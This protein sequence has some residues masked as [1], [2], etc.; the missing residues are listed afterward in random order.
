VHVDHRDDPITLGFEPEKEKEKKY[1]Y[2]YAYEYFHKITIAFSKEGQE[3]RIA[4]ERLELSCE[5]VEGELKDKAKDEKEFTREKKL[6][7]G[8][9]IINRKERDLTYS[10]QPTRF[11]I[12]LDNIY[13]LVYLRLDVLK[14]AR[15][16]KESVISQLFPFRAQFLFNEIALYDIEPKL[17]Q[18]AIPIT[19]KTEL[20]SNGENLALVLQNILEDEKKRQRF[21][22]LIKDL[23]PFIEEIEV[24]KTSDKSL[25]T[26]LEEVYSRDQFLPAFLLSEG[27][28]TITA[29]LIIFYFEEKPLVIIEEPA[30][31]IHPYL[32][33]KVIDMMKD[34]SEWKNKQIIV[35]T[36]NPEIVRYGGVKNLLFVHRDDNGFSRI[37]KPSEKKEVQ[38]FLSNKMGI[39]E[40][41]IQNLLKW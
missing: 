4:G 28:L 6:L 22:K 20:E 26:H 5:F 31:N 25:V 33:A 1:I 36:H 12:S 32:I 3:Y 34:V 7:D 21:K 27:T 18:H 10:I 41:Y 40:L 9:I 2:V 8:K 29:L 30:K 37:S 23:L 14:L 19:G 11:P 13:P 17:S 24:K 39:A 38:I 15:S 35:T 16:P